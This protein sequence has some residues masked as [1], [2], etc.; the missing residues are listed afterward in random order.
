MKMER[1]LL[2]KGIGGFYYVEAADTIY[3]A[4]AR[5]I[6][7]KRGITPLAGDIVD[8]SI[9]EDGTCTIEE[10]GERKN[11]LVRPPVANLD[12]LFLVV[13]VLHPSP[14]LLVLDKMLAGAEEKGIAPVIVFSKTDLEDCGEYLEI[15]QKTGIPVLTVSSVT[16]EGVD[17]VRELLQ[18]KLSVFS[19]NS[20]VGKS[21]L[22]NRLDERLSLPTAEI[23]QKLG[24]G[25]HTTRQVELLKLGPDTYVADTPG[26]SSVDMIQT[27]LIRKDTLARDF[28]E[29]V[30]YLDQCRFPS[31]SHTKEKGCAVLAALREG[32]IAPSRHQ[33]YV[34]MY[35]EIKNIKEWELK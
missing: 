29:F 3:E 20:G 21:S 8:I 15:Y 28:R 32:K 16:G 30:P 12:Q 27:E 33:S 14:N 5:G 23:S 9:E 2:R 34:T 31:C 26:F 17:R 22:L 6:F 25:R 19:G 18:G 1:G 35:D 24:R 4:K 7:R 13:S 10:I 11:S